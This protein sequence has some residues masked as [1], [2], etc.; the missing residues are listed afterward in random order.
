MRLTWLIFVSSMPVARCRRSCRTATVLD[1]GAFP[2]VAQPVYRD[3][4]PVESGFYGRGG[5]GDGQIVV[6]VGVEVEAQAG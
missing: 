2:A 4:D 6:V 3:V 1:S 5:I